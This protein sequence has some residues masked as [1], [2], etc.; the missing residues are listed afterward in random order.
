[1]WGKD[2]GSTTTNH[3]SRILKNVGGND[4]YRQLCDQQ[5]D[6]LLKKRCETRQQKKIIAD[7]TFEQ[8]EARHANARSHYANL[9]SEHSQA[10]V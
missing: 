6:G 9:K 4:R 10:Y 3:H 8:I 5:K 7:L 2:R 1:M